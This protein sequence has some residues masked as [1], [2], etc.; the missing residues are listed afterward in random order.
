MSNG[1]DGDGKNSI[2]VIARAAAILRSLRDE[3]EG[4]SLGQIADRVSLPRSTVQRIVGALQAE[5]LV[6]AA[7]PE[8][9]IR[10][11][12][13]LQSLAEA[14]RIDLAEMI[15]PFLQDLSNETEETVDLAVLRNDKMIFI[16]QIP[17]KQRLRAVSSIGEA[18]PLTTPANGKACLA[19]MEDDEISKV[20]TREWKALGVKRDIKAL[21]AE[22]QKARKSGVAFDEEEHSSGISAAGIAFKDSRGG[23]YGISVPTPSTRFLKKKAILVKALTRLS[24]RIAKLLQ[25]IDPV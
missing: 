9:G 22:L 5:R 21:L 2:Q 18:F 3:S 14:A 15:R 17:G 20:A 11:G 1:E 6:I 24:E 23:Y 13:E 19:L 4:L 8:G 25:T 16:D 7:S 12:P 10:L